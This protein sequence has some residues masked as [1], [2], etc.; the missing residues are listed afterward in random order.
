MKMNDL[1]WP[2]A[3]FLNARAKARL[4]ELHRLIDWHT[5]NESELE[6]IQK[7]LDILATM[8]NKRAIAEISKG[9]K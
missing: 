1:R 7:E 4:K 8:I 2:K 3:D 9:V 5:L 6:I